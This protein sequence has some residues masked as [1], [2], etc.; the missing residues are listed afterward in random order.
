MSVVGELYDWA[1]QPEFPNG[2][3]RHS[4]DVRPDPLFAIR[5]RLDTIRTPRPWELEERVD[6]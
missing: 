6:L 5:A 1:E 2:D 3:F 4:W